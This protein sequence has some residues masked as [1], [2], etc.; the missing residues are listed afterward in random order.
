MKKVIE[1]FVKC[2]LGKLYSQS[3]CQ[4]D[5]PS[6]RACE[7]ATKEVWY[8]EAVKALSGIRPSLISTAQNISE[9][10]AH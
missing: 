3:R 5:G 9:Q 2:L 10:T 6:S 4:N 7:G 8:D 1:S